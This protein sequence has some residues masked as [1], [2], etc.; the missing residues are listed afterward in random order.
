[1]VTYGAV[2][3]FFLLP[4]DFLPE[5][6]SFFYRVLGLIFT[7]TFLIPVL[8]TFSMK[9]FG[10][11]SSLQLEKQRE[12][13]WPLLVTAIVYVVAF[14]SLRSR[15][16]PGFI[17]LYLLGAIVGILFS[18]LVNLRWKIS[19][20]LIGIGGLCGGISAIMYTM[21]MGNPMLLAL[22]FLAAGILGTSRLI[23][24]AHTPA[25]ILA[26]FASGFAIEFLIMLFAFS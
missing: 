13:N 20:H 11:I 19:L 17:Q 4:S 15:V 16:I 12:R 1:M 8:F 22:C 10:Q 21:E 6:K 9:R 5:D 3:Y 2:I 14:Y 26:G 18:L 7:G 24:R 25:Q 23:L